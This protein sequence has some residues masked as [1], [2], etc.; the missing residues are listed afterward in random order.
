MSSDLLLQ[1][2]RLIVGLGNPGPQYDQ[3]RH[4]VGFWLIQQLAEE[5]QT[6]L[7]ETIK[8][9]GTHGKAN[10]NNQDVH[11]LMPNTFM[12][13]SGQAVIATAL[14]YK[15]KPQEILIVHDEL[16]LDVGTV[17]FKPN[18]GHGGHNGLRNIIALLKTNDFLR[19]RLGIGRPPGK[20]QGVDYVL[21]RPNKSDQEKIEDA[22][23]KAISLIPLVVTGEHEKAMQL[24]H[25]K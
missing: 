10:L 15:I 17:R 4:N 25:T 1:P 2:I 24:L 7:K 20:Q 14:Y 23:A 11:L 3:T 5:T 19:L 18:G 6:P 21:N 16:D 13:L 22:I 12:N 9:K 8:L